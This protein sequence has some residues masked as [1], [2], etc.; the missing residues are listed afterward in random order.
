MAEIEWRKIENFPDYLISADGNVKSFKH[1]KEGRLMSLHLDHSGYVVVT[2]RNKDSQIKTKKVHQLV[3]LSFI[4]L[5]KDKNQVNHKDGVK[6]NNHVSNLEWVNGSENLKHAYDYL[7][8][9]PNGIGIAQV[10]NNKII[11]TFKSAE[12]ASRQTGIDASS[13]RKVCRRKRK[14]AGGYIWRDLDGG[15][16]I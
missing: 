12:E 15:R 1:D 4:P 16:K 10:F 14:T 6:T 8:F 2:L 5:V 7:N 3:A 13:I 11:A 9:N